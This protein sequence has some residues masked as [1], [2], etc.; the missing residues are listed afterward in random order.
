MKNI[1]VEGARGTGKSTVTKILRE[2]I[3][4]STLINFTGFNEGGDDGFRKTLKYY[5]SWFNFFHGLKETDMIFIH[6]R[7]YFSEMVYSFLY[8]DYNFEEDYQIFNHRIKNNFDEVHLILLVTDSEELLYNRLN[9]NKKL[10]FGR[11]N[12]NVTESLKQQ[13][14]YKHFLDRIPKITGIKYHVIEVGD[15]TPEEI[16]Q[17]IIDITA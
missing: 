9:R 14:L 16:S 2:N 17:K 5:N 3:L 6:D 11:V 12:E 15:L 8:K 4:N 13:Y 1:I 10:L 7:F